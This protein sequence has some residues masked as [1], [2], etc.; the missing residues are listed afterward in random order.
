MHQAHKLSQPPALE[1]PEGFDAS[2][3]PCGDRA[4]RRRASHAR[5]A[6]RSL[7]GLAATSMIATV[8]AVA[9]KRDTDWLIWGSVDDRP[10]LFDVEAGAAEEMV[11][12]VS[13]G[14]TAT[15]II[16]PWQLVL[17]RID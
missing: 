2:G 10:V 9:E 12:A 14:E 8:E 11:G 15:A 13:R 16:E 7:P 1:M 4:A 17:E 5:R 3:V 6:H